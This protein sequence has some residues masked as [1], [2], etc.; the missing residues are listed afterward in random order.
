[1]TPPNFLYGTAWKER[2]TRRLTRM[3]VQAGFQGIDTA[4]QRKHYLEEAIAFLRQDLQHRIGGRSD[5]R[6]R[7]SGETQA[8]APT[9]R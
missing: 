2:K 3:A 5:A 1:M 7:R 8:G 6:D 9:Q 4:N